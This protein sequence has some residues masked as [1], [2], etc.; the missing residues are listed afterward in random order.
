VGGARG[1]DD[2]QFR[3]RAQLTRAVT[4]WS[5]VALN[6]SM[7][8]APGWLMSRSTCGMSPTNTDGTRVSPFL[9]VDHADATEL[10]FLAIA[11]AG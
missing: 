9:D 6:M 7:V 3:V 11:L 4:A 10:E 2:E 1:H 8:L 5:R